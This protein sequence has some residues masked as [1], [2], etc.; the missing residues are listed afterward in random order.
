MLARM[1][2]CALVIG[3]SLV[4]A[5]TVRIRCGNSQSYTASDGTTWVADQYSTGGQQLYTGYQV[6]ST[7]DPTLYR[8]ARQG[9]YGDFSYNIPVANGNYQLTLKFA[10]I[11]YASAGARVFNVT[12][13]GAA[14]LTNFDIVAQAG[15]WT[16]I[17]KQFPVTVTNGAVQ[18]NVHGVTDV[19]LLNA[20][21][22]APA[23]GGDPTPALQVSGN[24]LTFSGMAGGSNPAAQT[25][26]IANTGG[27]TL[28][29]T[30]SKTQSWLS[31]SATSGTA[32]ATLTIGAV[33]TGLAA[34]TYSDTV[35]IAASGA[36]GSPKTVSVTLN[37]SAAPPP[38]PALSL[39]GTAVSFSATAG[40]SNPAAKNITITNSGG[41]TL[42]WTA[43]KGQPWLTLSAASGT[44]P[45]SLGLTVSTSGLAA[46]TY[47]DTVTIAAPGASG[48]PEAVGVTLTVS[49]STGT[50]SASAAYVRLDTTTQGSWKNVYGADGYNFLGAAP[51]LP[52]YAQ[53]SVS[54]AST[55][56]WA[57]STSDPRALEQPSGSNRTAATWFA[58]GTYSFDVNL[59][60][61]NTH[62]LA[63]YAIDYDNSGRSQRI[64]IVDP[65]T[66]SVLDSR[67][68]SGFAAGQYL[69]WNLSGHLTIQL[70][71]L[72]G[73]NVVASGLFLDVPGQAPN[74]STAF[75]R[76]DTST[77]G[78]WK[79]AY[80][81][82]GY[83]FAA[84]APSLPSYAQV[85]VS[86]ASSYTW[87]SSTSDVR[88]LELPSGTGRFAATWY[89][90]GSFSFDVNFTDGLT[91]Q[92]ALYAMDY[93]SSGRS[94]R[95]DII[96][97]ASGVVL[98]SRTM[99]AFSAGQYLVWNLA[100]H[101]TIRVTILGGSNPVVS[102][103]FFGGAPQQ[104]LPPA[105][106]LATNA[107]SFAGVAGGSNPSAQNVAIT[108]SG[109]GAL[110]WTAAKTQ[111]WLT[112]SAGLGTAPA[113][114]GL[115]VATSGLAA[116]TYTDTIT[117]TAP[118]AGSSP[119]T[120]T[121]TLTL[122][123]PPVLGVAPGALNF[124]GITGGAN[125]ATQ[126]LNILNTGA[127][128]LNWT[129]SKIQPWLSLSQTSGSGPAPVTVTVA[130]N[131]LAPGTYADT[132]TVN[133]PGALSSP[134]TVN[135]TLVVNA[136]IPILSVSSN[137]VSFSATAG[138]TNPAPQSVTIANMGIGTLNWTASKTQSWLTLSATS[139]TAPSTLGLTIS[140]SGLSAGT[141]NDVL[142]IAASGANGSPKT[143]A[144]T[145][146][147][148]A[149]AGNTAAFIRLD[150]GAQG[151]WKTVY[152]GEGYDFLGAAPLLPSYAQVAVNEAFIYTWAGSSTDPRALQQPTGNDRVAA[153]WYAAGGFN[154]DLNFTDGLT[155]QFALYATDFDGS[156]RSERIDIV[157]GATNLVLDSRALTG[158]GAGQYLVWN[159]SGHVVVRVTQVGPLNA[160]VSGLFFDA[161]GQ[162][163][164]G[165]SLFALL[166]E[167]RKEIG[168]I[169]TDE[170]ATTSRAKRPRFLP[171]RK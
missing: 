129:A 42:N 40:A 31:L 105:L 41:G 44:A 21:Q 51:A 107:I 71:Q 78:S 23:A 114:L 123:A 109:N 132:I 89:G 170:T 60:D 68:M 106:H 161:A 24:S 52:S 163:P 171:M 136:A 10:E 88:A 165:S 67:T 104:N 143:V 137:A 92:L 148:S 127:G 33:T 35:T 84:A 30:A 12:V 159:V 97:S 82:D 125:P 62:Q 124:A 66:G 76:L 63:L 19:G 150:T 113:S 73:S 86:G 160:V 64:D 85:A 130:T 7:A 99:S 94:Q 126:T 20:I 135:V 95:A 79:A 111:P 29:W 102:G 115:A 145:L 57:A 53:V 39:S 72:V 70:T 87:A 157:D 25:V 151:N 93:D 2:C 38:S 91:H 3:S 122:T 59:T 118:G 65:A 138:F 168:L 28:N 81:A 8:W 120:V 149:A 9:Y 46:G 162:S 116:G 55:Y 26:T 158:F 6:A 50:G 34:G 103:L 153:T 22:I 100:G 43:S 15:Y 69:V 121:V 1:L 61:G 45:S 164:V 112:L 140:A 74:G 90:T 154:F 37:V 169:L 83:D 5:Q 58:A 77:Q 110:N 56:T 54:G 144:V 13:N 80:G 17:D 98:D 155:H 142:T 4:S 101:V 27:G 119:Q 131:G 36:S 147:L 16:A 18:I 108:N 133:A 156:G 47:T 167:A 146:T 75:V 96:D 166:D 14:V 117:V 134:Q 141:Y 49:A 11:Q 128:T 48:S 152:G 32:P 139:G